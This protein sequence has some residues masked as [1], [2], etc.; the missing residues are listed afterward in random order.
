MSA[1]PDYYQLLSVPRSAT[2]DEIR[3]AYKKESLRCAVPMMPSHTG[4]KSAVS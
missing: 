2:T 3:Q 4:L 1:L